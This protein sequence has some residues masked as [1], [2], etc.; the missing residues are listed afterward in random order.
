M[1]QF[2]KKCKS[3]TLFLIDEFGTGSDPEL[4]GA[5]AET[6]LEVFYERKA[7][8]VITT[9]YANL[10]LLAS[11]LPHATNANMQFD[12]QSLEPMYQ[13][14]LGEAGSSFTFEVAQKNGIPYSLINKAKKKIE[15][16]KVRFDK[17][18]ANLQKERSQLRK[19]SESLKT[20][21]QKAREQSKYLEETNSK[22]KD[23]LESYQELYDSNQRLISLGKKLDSL[24]KKY[25]NNKKKKPLLDELFKLVLVENSK[26]KKVAPAVKKKEKIKKLKVVKEVEKKVAVI[27]KRKKIEKEKAKKLPPPKPK[28]ILKLGDRVRML[29]GNAIGT[30]DKIEKK[31]AF[32]NYGVFTT[33][34]DLSELEKV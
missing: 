8:G 3:T 20:E 27:R 21:E 32:V 2:L 10:K 33:N 23:K 11:E 6:F 15:R 29:D 14:Q 26:I 17:S 30:I 28:E 4:G 5:L 22:I 24:S 31:K 9:H 7:F 25:H 13:L 34:V 12:S 16:G 18:I 1:N 19:T